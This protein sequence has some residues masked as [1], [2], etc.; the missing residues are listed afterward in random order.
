M[1]HSR[2]RQFIPGRQLQPP[3]NAANKCTEEQLNTDVACRASK[4]STSESCKGCV[5]IATGDTAATASGCG[6]A[7][8]DYQGCLTAACESCGDDE[9]LFE[10][11][12]TTAEEGGCKAFAD[13][14]E[15]KCPME[16]VNTTILAV[17]KK[18][19]TDLKAFA[20]VF[21]GSG[22]PDAN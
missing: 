8:T 18:Y 15:L 1:P 4:D 2:G 10:Q 13:N 20:R 5:G 17:C 11:C 3:F 21:C 9:A 22:V 14:L 7:L 12:A 19:S 16:K 6:K